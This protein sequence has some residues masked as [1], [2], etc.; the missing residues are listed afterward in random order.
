MPEFEISSSFSG[1]DWTR[2]GEAQ[3]RRLSLAVRT[4]ATGLERIMKRSITSEPKHG[5][6]YDRPGGKPH[7][8]SA[9]G[10]PPASDTGTLVNSIQTR[11]VAELES[12]VVVGAEYGAELEYGRVRVAPRP[13]VRPAARKIAEPFARACRLA[14]EWKPR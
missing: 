10:E 3:M 1:S 5:I 9:P 14:M 12:Q 8:A 11:H 13:F 6:L 2:I 4:T 7:R